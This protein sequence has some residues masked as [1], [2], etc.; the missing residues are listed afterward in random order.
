MGQTNGS[1][2]RSQKAGQIPGATGAVIRAEREPRG[3]ARGT[4]EDRRADVYAFDLSRCELS[5]IARRTSASVVVPSGVVCC[6][7]KELAGEST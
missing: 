7:W 5:M 1:C 4:W 6:P 2:G 3:R